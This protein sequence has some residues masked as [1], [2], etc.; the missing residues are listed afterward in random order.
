VDQPSNVT[1]TYGEHAEKKRS[2]LQP[3]LRSAKI[4]WVDEWAESDL[5]WELADTLG[6]LL[7]DH[8]RAAIYTTIGSGYSYTAITRLVQA[9]ALGGYALPPRLVDRLAEWLDAYTHSDDAARLLQ[10]LNA[11]RTCSSQNRSIGREGAGS[12]DE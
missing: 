9:S 10:L 1:V 7:P 8:D 6:P 4:S 5:A 12:T 3:T 11:I 2:R